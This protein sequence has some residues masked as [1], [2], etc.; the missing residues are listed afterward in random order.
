MSTNCTT[1]SVSDLCSEATHFFKPHA[2]AIFV[3][4]LK[5][6]LVLFDNMHVHVS[7]N[8]HCINAFFNDW[9]FVFWWQLM[10]TCLLLNC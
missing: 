10:G 8:K 9:C 6:Q 2:D 1:L 7:F 3:R 4:T 5:V